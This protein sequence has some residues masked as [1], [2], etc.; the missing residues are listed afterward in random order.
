MAIGSIG[1]VLDTLEFDTGACEYPHIINISGDIFAIVY[2][3][4]DG[5]GW[6]VTTNGWTPE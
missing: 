5:D 4:S 3:G 2:Q 1:S 6:L